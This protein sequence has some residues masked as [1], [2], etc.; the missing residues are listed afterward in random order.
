MANHSLRLIAFDIL[1]DLKQTM[2]DKELT[3]SKVAFYVITVANNLKSKHI[4]N[5]RSGAFMHTFPEIPIIRSTNNNTQDLIKN[6]PSI[7]LPKSIYDFDLDG[8]VKYVKYS[9]K[10]ECSKGFE[11]VQFTRTEAG[12]KAERLYL[13]D[14][15][16][17][18]PANPYWYR[19]GSYIVL[20]GIENT[21]VKKLEFGLFSTIDPLTE[22]DIDKPFDFPEELIPVLKRQVLDLGRFILMIPSERVNDGA[23]SIKNQDVPTQKLISV[24]DVS[25]QNNQPQQ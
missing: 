7:F 10:D 23:D 4:Q 9:D 11:R 22:I 14:Y 21:T 2:D 20:L 3:L 1:S 15:E 16:K 19:T 18:S 5:R 6:R 8:G 12:R 13:T 25:Q 24:N 17:P